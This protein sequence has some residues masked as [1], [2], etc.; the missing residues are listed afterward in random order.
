MKVT[1]LILLF[2]SLN[3]FAQGQAKTNARVFATIIN[4]GD[5]IVNKV[6]EELNVIK[7]GMTYQELKDDFVFPKETI[8][9]PNN[10]LKLTYEDCLVYIDK[11]LVVIVRKI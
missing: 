11:D 8:L 4:V 5:T 1:I 7:I 10:K 9:L 3:C 2:L 6:T